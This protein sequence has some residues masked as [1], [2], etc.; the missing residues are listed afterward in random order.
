MVATCYQVRM[1][2][3][4]LT[5]AMELQGMQEVPNNHLTRK[6]RSGKRVSALP[7]DS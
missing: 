6:R 2:R 7:I 1:L 4:D 3:L 5:W